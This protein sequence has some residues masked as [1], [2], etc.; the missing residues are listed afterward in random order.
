MLLKLVLWYHFIF[1]WYIDR[2]EVPLP[3]GIEL[4][5]H[6]N[7]NNFKASDVLVPWKL[8]DDNKTFL[9]FY[10]VF[11]EHE[12]E[13]MCQEIDNIDIVRSY[14]DQGNWCILFRRVK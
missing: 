10:H 11:E 2:Q 4:P 9:R 8:K 1:V 7:R 3:G 12:L 14:Y 5:I 6:V 13:K